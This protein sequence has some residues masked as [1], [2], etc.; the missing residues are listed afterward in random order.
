M[1]IYCIV[2]LVNKLF[3]SHQ[4]S[5]LVVYISSATE[6]TPCFII[7]SVQRSHDTVYSRL[8]HEHLSGL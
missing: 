8:G 7:P 2:V 5:V 4:D 3:L 6:S 1:V